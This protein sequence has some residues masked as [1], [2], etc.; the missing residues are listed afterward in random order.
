[1]ADKRRL[2][3]RDRR[4]AAAVGLFMRLLDVAEIQREKLPLLGEMLEVYDS[5]QA[6]AQWACDVCPH[7]LKNQKTGAFTPFAEVHYTL[8]GALLYH[9]RILVVLPR[10][11]GKST[12]CTVIYPLY[13]ICEKRKRYLMLGSYVAAN[14]RKFVYTVRQELEHNHQIRERYGDLRTEADKWTDEF[15]I[16]A[17]GVVVEAIYYGKGDLRGSRYIDVRPD[18]VVLDDLE[19]K[20]EARNPERVADL[21]AW[22]DD[23]VAK[24][25]IEVQIIVVGTILC[26]G[27]AI[28]QLV[29]KAELLTDAAAIF[30]DAEE[31]TRRRFRLVMVEACDADF[32]NC[33]WPE[34]FPADVLRGMRAGNEDSFDQE[35]RHLPRTR[36]HR[37]FREFHFYDAAD[38]P[39]GAPLKLF[40]FTDLVPGENEIV[41]RRG[42]D[43]DYFARVSVAMRLDTRKLFVW[44]AF[45]ARD[46]TKHEMVCDALDEYER[47]REIDPT[48]RIVGEANGFQVW[49]LE[50]L[51]EEAAA[52]GYVPPI[53]GV[54]SKGHKVDRITSH[55]TTVNTG[56]VRFRRD[57]PHQRLL[58]G[59]LKHVRNSTVH[60]DLAD[61][62]E[63]C[64]AQARMYRQA[65]GGDDVAVGEYN[66][67]AMGYAG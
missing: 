40:F 22:I 29:E 19:T 14:A 34:L 12:I 30:P 46:L 16:T 3:P 51:L 15:F 17:D 63:G 61:A 6:I 62:W 21:L 41:R 32:G 44:S 27:S 8:F 26:D 20:D 47:L 7:L 5:A 52:R 59:E 24:L 31:N 54:V 25:W 1:V 50:A 43:T 9:L 28:H 53:E 36:K 64:M 65:V 60:D 18:L 23:E 66:P 33:A 48:V 11:F 10:G 37:D 39:A 45:H 42:K 4:I 38:V 58:I 13:C 57:D 49:F 67:T 35:M 56:H 2:L 55:D